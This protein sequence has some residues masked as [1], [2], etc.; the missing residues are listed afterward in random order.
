MQDKKIFSSQEIDQNL[1][2]KSNRI[3]QIRDFFCNGDNTEFALKLQS[4]TNY[5]SSL[6]NGKKP[7][8][9]KVLNKILVAF[10]DVS[11]SWLYFGEGE[12]VSGKKFSIRTNN[13][14]GNNYQGEHINSNQ[15]ELINLVKSQ[16]ETIS[17][18]TS[19]I[20]KLIS[21]IEQKL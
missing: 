19:Q 10:P 20:D 8:G 17:K 4:S 1:I 5:T 2:E 21:I 11:R 15:E 16:Q 6:C 3:S 7:I 12:M 18:Q 9:E 14:H 13:Q